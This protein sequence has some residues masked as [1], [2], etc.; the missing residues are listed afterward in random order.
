MCM[1]DH[2]CWLVGW[3]IVV[4]CI[5]GFLLVFVGFV[6]CFVLKKWGFLAF[7]YFSPKGVV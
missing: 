5:E 4:R 1:C 7:L 6:V 2:D 3:I